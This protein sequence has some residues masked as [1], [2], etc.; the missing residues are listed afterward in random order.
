MLISIIM[1]IIIGYVAN[2][3]VKNNMPGGIIGSMVAG[4]A[5]AWLGS[6]LLG[7][8]GPVVGGFAIV[9]AII[10]AVIVI[11]L[12]GLITRGRK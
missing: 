3:F 5:G 10:G 8:F 1:A 2:I 12:I 9:P 7:S 6:S 11:F 4:F